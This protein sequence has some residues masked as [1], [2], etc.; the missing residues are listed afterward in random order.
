MSSLIED[1]YNHLFKDHNSIICRA[2]ALAILRVVCGSSSCRGP[3]YRFGLDKAQLVSYEFFSTRRD[4]QG[5]QLEARTPVLL[6]YFCP[7]FLFQLLF[8]YLHHLLLLKD[9]IHKITTHG[10]TTVFIS[11]G[12]TSKGGSYLR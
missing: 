3:P 10:L 6:V 4:P 12:I 1:L 8:L 9:A 2:Q 5:L 11:Q 7:C